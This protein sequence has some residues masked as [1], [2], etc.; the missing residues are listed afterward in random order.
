MMMIM[1]ILRMHTMDGDGNMTAVML[2]ILSMRVMTAII[3]DTLDTIN[4]ES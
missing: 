1:M 2:L 4:S 3:G